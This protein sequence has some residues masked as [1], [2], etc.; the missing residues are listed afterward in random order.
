M[1]YNKLESI[2]ARIN[3][4]V[5]SCKEWNDLKEGF[6]AHS[7]HPSNRMVATS[8][9]CC[10]GFVLDLIWESHIYGRLIKCKYQLEA[11]QTDQIQEAIK[12]FAAE[13]R[14]FKKEKQEAA[15]ENLGKVMDELVKE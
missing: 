3:Y 14:K 12:R 4:A 11:L 7:Y 13:V 2:Q 6:A 1:E 10:D 15:W 9:Q 5:T 8:R